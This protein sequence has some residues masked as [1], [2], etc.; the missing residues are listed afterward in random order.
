[1]RRRAAFWRNLSN[2]SGTF[3]GTRRQIVVTLK[4]PHTLTYERFNEE[5]KRKELAALDV[6]LKQQPL[7]VLKGIGDAFYDPLSFEGRSRRALGGVHP[8]DGEVQRNREASLHGPRTPQLR[9]P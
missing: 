7:R 1:M 2:L 3:E 5:G 8:N 4:D 6:A 9:A